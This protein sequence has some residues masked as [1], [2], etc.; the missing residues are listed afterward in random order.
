[1]QL[2]VAGGTEPAVALRYTPPPAMALLEGDRVEVRAVAAPFVFAPVEQGDLL[3]HLTICCNG[4]PVAELPLTAAQPVEATTPS[5][6][7][8]LLERLFT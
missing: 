8:S 5:P 6:R 2:P 3:G 1:M 7:E 4:E